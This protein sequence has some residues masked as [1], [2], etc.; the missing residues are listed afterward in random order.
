MKAEPTLEDHLKE[1]WK[2]VYPGAIADESE[3]KPV[4]IKDIQKRGRRKTDDR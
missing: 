4:S 3:F 1:I 2:Q